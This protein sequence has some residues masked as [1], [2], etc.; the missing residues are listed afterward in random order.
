LG[1]EIASLVSEELAEGSYSK[2]WNASAMP[3]GVYFYR[4]SA[5]PSDQRDRSPNNDRVEQSKP[6]VETQKLI[7]LR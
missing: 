1:R 4:F 3:S 2:H 6:F 7:L 5:L